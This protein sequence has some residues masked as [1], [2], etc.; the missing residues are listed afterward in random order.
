MVMTAMH[1]SDLAVRNNIDTSI[2]LGWKH[3]TSDGEVLSKGVLDGVLTRQG[4]CWRA[5]EG[6]KYTCVSL[7][8][9]TARRHR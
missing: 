3:A 5:E 8:Y 7:V 2:F 4:I 1:T 9:L 6:T